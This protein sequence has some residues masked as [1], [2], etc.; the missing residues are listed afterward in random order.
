MTTMTTPVGG[1]SQMTEESKNALEASQKRGQWEKNLRVGDSV[2]VAQG[3]YKGRSGLLIEKWV[4]GREGGPLFWSILSPSPQ[5]DLNPPQILTVY[6]HYL[7]P[8]SHPEGE[9]EYTED[10]HRKQRFPL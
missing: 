8:F 3:R 7:E 4:S 6:V 5:G 1:V 9:T 10:T 2:R